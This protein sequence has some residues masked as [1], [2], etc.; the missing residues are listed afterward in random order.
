MSSAFHREETLAGGGLRKRLLRLCGGVWNYPSSGKNQGKLRTNQ[1]QLTPAQDDERKRKFRVPRFVA[2]N[3][4]VS[5]VEFHYPR[6]HYCLI[7]DLVTL[8]PRHDLEPL[9]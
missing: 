5:K 4:A 6:G 8:D 3:Q 9:M 1:S 7:M 2:D